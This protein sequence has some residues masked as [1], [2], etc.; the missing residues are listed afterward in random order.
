M[1]YARRKV[2]LPANRYKA[3]GHYDSKG[4]W[5]MTRKKE[6]SLDDAFDILNSNK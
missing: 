5:I 2:G 6:Q 4:N 1:G 3:K